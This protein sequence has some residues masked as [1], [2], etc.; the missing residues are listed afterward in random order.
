MKTAAAV[1]VTFTILDAQDKAGL[2]RPVMWRRRV[3]LRGLSR[4]GRLAAV[5]SVRQHARRRA[6]FARPHLCPPHGRKNQAK[7]PDTMVVFDRDGKFIKVVGQRE[8][9]EAERMDCAFKGKAALNF[10]TCAT[11][12]TASSLRPRSTVRRFSA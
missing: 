4:L 8:F 6:R 10:C 12:F 11:F 5:D 2:K 7:A 3:H 1:P 9:K